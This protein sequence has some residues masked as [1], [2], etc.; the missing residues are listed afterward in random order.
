MELVNVEIAGTGK[1]VWIIEDIEAFKLTTVK[2][3]EASKKT[4]SFVN[5]TVVQPDAY[6][7]ISGGKTNILTICCQLSTLIKELGKAL[8]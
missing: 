8:S 4:I 6:I 2:G 7:Q 5:L 1:K 3:T